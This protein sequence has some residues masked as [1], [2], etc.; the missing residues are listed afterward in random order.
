M[1]AVT[2]LRRAGAKCGARGN[3]GERKQHSVAAVPMLFSDEILFLFIFLPPP[4]P[5]AF[6]GN[7]LK[8]GLR[9]GGFSGASHLNPSA[10]LDAREGA[11][12]H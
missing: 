8:C 10:S 3:S 2:L 4:P 9:R 5:L 12:F 11:V 6:A 7:V 1:A